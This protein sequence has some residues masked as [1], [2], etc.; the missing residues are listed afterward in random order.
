MNKM[1]R[2]E[3]AKFLADKERALRVALPHHAKGDWFEYHM[4]EISA[5]NMAIEALQERPNGRWEQFMCFNTIKQCSVCGCTTDCKPNYCPN[6]G[7]DMRGET[8]E[9]N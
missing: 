5:I 1:D 9:T 4:K 7:A 2:K 3:A 8:D 6:C